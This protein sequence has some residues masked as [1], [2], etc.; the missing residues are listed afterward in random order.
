MRRWEWLTERVRDNGWVR[1]AELGVKDGQ[2]LYYLLERCP[3]LFMV[4]VDLWAPQ[5]ERG[6]YGYADWPHETHE[7][8]ARIRADDFP[9]RVYLIKGATVEAAREIEDGSLDFVFIDAD[10]ST[11]AVAADATAWRPK[12]RPGGMLCGHDVG[13]PSVQA[14][15]QQVCPGYRLAGHDGIWIA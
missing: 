12:I 6:D 3:A 7:R 2:T 5:P 10:H 1:G 15:L 4:G 11:D 9:G 13:W 8:Q 14:A